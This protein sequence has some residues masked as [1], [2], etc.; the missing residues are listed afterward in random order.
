[1]GRASQAREFQIA[2]T[3]TTRTTVQTTFCTVI[4]ILSTKSSKTR[5]FWSVFACFC[6]VFLQNT[7]IY[8][9]VTIKAFQNI[10][11][12][13]VS[14]SLVSPNPWKH[15]YL[16]CFRQFFHAGQL[17][18][19][20]KKSFKKH[21]FLQCVYNVFRQKH[22]NLHVFQHKVGPR[23]W[24]VQCFQCSG[25]QKPFKTS[26]FTIFFHFC[27]FFHCRKPTKMTQKSIS[28]PS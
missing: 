13:T 18:H 28:M 8:T 14:N 19:I 17:K 16:H 9:F 22:R 2:T 20:Y 1:M 26:L 3:T 12:Y 7:V 23:H 27:P 24:F 4:C 11:F 15:R 6:N 25:I 10:I 21:C 5:V